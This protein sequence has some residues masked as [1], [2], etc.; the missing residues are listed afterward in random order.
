MD[1]ITPAVGITVIFGDRRVAMAI[2]F[3]LWPVR[4]DTAPPQ[5][6]QSCSRVAVAIHCKLC[7]EVLLKDP[8]S[9]FTLGAHTSGF[10]AEGIVNIS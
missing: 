7:R 8:T 5:S 3:Y 4:V 9:G 10:K 6:L 1:R 2:R